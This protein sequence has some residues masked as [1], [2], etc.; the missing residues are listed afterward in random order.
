VTAHVIRIWERRYRALAPTRTGTNRRMYSEEDVRRLKMLGE[1][2][3]RGH[4]IGCIAE[5]RLDE[6]EHLLQGDSPRGDRSFAVDAS[7][8]LT[9]TEDYVAACLTAAKSFEGDRLRRLL[10]RAR[11]QF[12]QR[13]MLRQVIAPLISQIGVAWQEGLLRSGQEHLGTAMI[14]E[15]LMT[16]VPGSQTA[17]NAPEIVVATPSGEIHE[18]GALLV[19]ASARDLGWRV[20]YL[21]PNLPSEEIAACARARKVRAVALSVVYPE[22][23]PTVLAQ[24]RELRKLL[25]GEILLAVGGR[26]A[27]GYQAVLGDWEGKIEWLTDLPSLDRLLGTAEGMEA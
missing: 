4:R 16:P 25:P 5:L 27:S 23:C 8:E 12:G 18:L 1:L 11:L 14:R 20:T 26:S 3:A 6:L 13:G 7:P 15:V 2:T 21:G 19:A 9:T 10:Q 24:I 22:N 17:T